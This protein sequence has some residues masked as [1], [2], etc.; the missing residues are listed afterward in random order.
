MAVVGFAKG[1]Q[2]AGIDTSDPEQTVVKR[3]F[4]PMTLVRT[5]Q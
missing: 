2:T 5:Q 1:S 4:M 3:R